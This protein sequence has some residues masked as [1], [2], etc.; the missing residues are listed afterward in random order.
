MDAACAHWTGPHPRH[1]GTCGMMPEPARGRV[2]SVAWN[3]IAARRWS[4]AVAGPRRRSRG[5][6][7]LLST[8]K[9]AGRV[10]SMNANGRL[11]LFAR[12]ARLARFRIRV[13][14]A[15]GEGR[16]IG[17]TAPALPTQHAHPRTAARPGRTA[18]PDRVQPTAPTGLLAPGSPV[19]LPASRACGVSEQMTSDQLVATGGSESASSSSPSPSFHAGTTGP[20]V[21]AAGDPSGSLCSFGAGACQAFRCCTMPR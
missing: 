3:A 18:S 5:G 7:L 8:C 1:D 10:R 21:D 14:P 9:G 20:S 2:A 11:V 12:R 17:W 15:G 16:L 4:G 6:P 13:I 19:V